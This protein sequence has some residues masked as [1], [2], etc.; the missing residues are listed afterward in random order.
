MNVE[1]VRVTIDLPKQLVEGIRKSAPNLGLSE[2]LMW[3]GLFGVGSLN[4]LVDPNSVVVMA[5]AFAQN[6]KGAE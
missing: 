2:R 4:V 1:T 5:E 3:I 6:E